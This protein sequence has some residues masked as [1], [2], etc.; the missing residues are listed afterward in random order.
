MGR[1]LVSGLVGGLFPDA[2]GWSIGTGVCVRC[3]Q[4]HGAVELTGVP[5]VASVSYARGLVVAA[6]APSA[7]G[8]QA[9]RRRRARCVRHHAD[10]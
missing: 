6:V 10:A 5:A 2:S 7:G 8:G 3:G 1:S 4:R 9:R